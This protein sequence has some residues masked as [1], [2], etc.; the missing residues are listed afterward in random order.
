METETQKQT[1][2]EATPPVKPEWQATKENWYDHLNITVKQLDI[3][4]GVASGLLVLVFILIILQ[5]LHIL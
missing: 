5:G 1:A 3:I 4:I 2:E